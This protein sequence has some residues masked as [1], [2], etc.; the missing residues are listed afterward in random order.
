LFAD[1]S[2][3]SPPISS[4]RSKAR[5]STARIAMA[6]LGMPPRGLDATGARRESWWKRR[7]G[8]RVGGVRLRSRSL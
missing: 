7:E 1:G 3:S 4:I 6:A 2:P 8:K 5:P